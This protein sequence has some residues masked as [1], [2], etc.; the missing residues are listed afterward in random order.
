[1]S[2]VRWIDAV[3]FDLDGLLV[4]SEPVQYAAWDAFVACYGR[5]L[6]SDLKRRM[7]GTRLVD[8]AELVARELELPLTAAEVAS[9]RDAIFFKM[10]PGRI[11]AKP[12]AVDLLAW[13]GRH[14]IPTA[15]ATSGHRVYVDLAIESA[16]I[17]HVF[18]VEVTGDQVCHG[19][20][21][22]ETFQTAAR[23][24]G[25]Q[26]ERSLVL[27]DS[28]QGVAAA[29]AAGALCFAVPDDP[30]EREVD[31]SAAHRVLASLDDARAAAADYGVEFSTSSQG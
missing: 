4:D 1:M 17:Q 22:P 3:I 12:G 27:E 29:V 20:P 6:T 21:H 15:L 26:P 10:I 7:Y 16:A 31:L 11:Q 2:A 30:G 25:V 9:E 14:G 5:S 28:P 13:L 23:L 24:L 18:T 19:K 8:S